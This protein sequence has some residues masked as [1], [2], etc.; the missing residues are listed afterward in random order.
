[1]KILA[2]TNELTCTGAPIILYRFLASI[3]REHQIQVASA[4]GPGP[5]GES[6]AASEIPVITQVKVSDFDVVLCNTLLTSDFISRNHRIIPSVWWI[7]E[8][9]F[10]LS[11]IQQGTVNTDAFRLA[12]RIVL[13]TRWQASALYGSWLA[14][15]EWLHI[16]Y[17]VALPSESLLNPFEQPDRYFNLVHLGT[18]EPRK[19]QD[20]T[21]KAIRQVNDPAIRVF[22]VG[23]L[24][25]TSVLDITPAER[26]RMVVI[27]PVL[28]ETA[29]AY[30]QHS[31]ALILPTRDDNTP[32]ALL[33]AMWL[34]RCVI[35][36]DFGP[37]SE[38]IL[39]GN[40]GL[41]AEV[42][43]IKTLAANI[44]F[45]KQNP[46]SRAA[47]ARRGAAVVRQQHSFEQHRSG[48]LHALESA[49]AN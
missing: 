42:E 37:I 3:C 33:E 38:L 28:Q 1:V 23:T 14:G 46:E 20:L 41:L 43:D 24:R 15:R 25:D 5:L 21:I 6:Y 39:H 7:H 19:G 44:A 22:F 45:V 17:G 34:E 36:S 26:E 4:R 31:D 13:P 35:S 12:T 30:L 29:V 32:M 11:L 40:N 16:P 49:V 8:P 27:G 2:I 10:G 48:M 9:R 47:I 18:I